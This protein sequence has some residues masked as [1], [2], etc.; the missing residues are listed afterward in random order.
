MGSLTT[1]QSPELPWF[2]RPTALLIGGAAVILAVALAVFWPAASGDRALTAVVER[3]AL[4]MQVT[5]SGTLTPA[6]SIGY[7]SPLSG[8]EA[9][10]IS[11]APEGT[12]VG[13]GDLLVRL[14]TT[15]LERELERAVQEARGARIELQVAEIEW[16]A[17]QA[18]LDSL[19][20]GEGALNI[21]E[22]QA[23]LQA[24]E[25]K[26]ARLTAELKTLKP[27]FDKGFITREE[28]SRPA[29]ALE[30][31]EAELALDRQRASVL[32]DR[33]H[34]REEQ[35]A[36]LQLAQRAAQRENV[37]TRALEAE[38]R[39]KLLRDQI[40]ASSIYARRP[41]LVVLEEY[42]AANPRRKVRVGDRVTASQTLITIP[43]VDRM[44]LQAL[45]SEADVHKLKVGQ[46]AAI[47]LEAFPA[48]RL[49]GKV[50]GIGTIAGSSSDRP[51]ED[52]RFDLV[53]ELD[54]ADPGL[55]PQMTARADIDLGERSNVLLIPVNAVFE[56]DGLP[57]A[58]VSHRWTTETRPVQL[59]ESNGLQVEVLSGLSEGERVRLDDVA[60]QGGASPAPAGKPLAPM[61]GRTAKDP[62]SPR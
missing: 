20:E 55:R 46:P 34:P 29:D 47:R 43:E 42:L 56:R 1:T 45:V 60:V 7:R 14:D 57:V 39:V 2:R 61:T 4:R 9:E 27:L 28:L 53:V 21:K 3:G 49:T 10:V 35:R 62:L 12:H 13:E 22:A 5:V 11:L 32:V 19:A 33:T 24:S 40:E 37:R 17:A 16:Q 58:H 54:S 6:Q 31:A 25:K 59:G 44:L 23:R 52:K 8:R 48:L 15:D 36:K 38:A 50:A 51:R 26:V 18:A 41:G 30:A